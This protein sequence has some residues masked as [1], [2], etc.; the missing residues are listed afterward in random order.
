MSASPLSFHSR[1][2]YDSSAVGL[3]PVFDGED[4]HGIAVIVEAN[5]ISTDA[6]AKLRRFDVLKALDIALPGCVKRANPCRIRIAVCRSTARTSA[7]AWPVQA[8]FLATVLLVRAVL[9]R[10]KR[11]AAHSLEVL[12]G[13][14]E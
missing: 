11:R 7:L 13:E 12:H 14:T 4:L 5:A 8:I 9:F 3:R 1:F 6:Q 10:R 2:P